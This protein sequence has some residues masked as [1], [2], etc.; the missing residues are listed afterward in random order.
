M[1]CHN[2]HDRPNRATIAHTVAMPRQWCTI[3]R[4]VRAWVSPP[5]LN[6]YFYAILR[7]ELPP[8]RAPSAANRGF[9]YR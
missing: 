8:Q 6:L 1:R 7:P 4:S 5:G 9:P 2:A 3:V